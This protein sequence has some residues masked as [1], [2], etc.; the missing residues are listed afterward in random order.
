M[1]NSKNQSRTRVCLDARI[2]LSN[3][4]GWGR[5]ATELSLALAERDEFAITVLLPDSEAA[6]D[7]L[8]RG[9]SL[10]TMRIIQTRFIA[11]EP[12]AFWD[13]PGSEPAE[14]YA[15]DVEL[16]HSLTR[17]AHH[18]NVRLRV[19]TVHDIVPLSAT[20]FKLIYA[21]ATKR[22]LRVL[23]D[24][25]Y[26][27]ITDSAFTKGELLQEGTLVHSEINV[28]HLAAADC[29]HRLANDVAVDTQSAVKKFLYVGGAGA[30]KN[31]DRLG[32]AIKTVAK[33]R[34]DFELVLAGARDWGYASLPLME[35][36]HPIIKYVQYVS[37]HELVKY[38]REAAALIMPSLH[39]GFGL[40]L[41]EAIAS[42]TPVICSDI[43]PFKEIAGEYASY[44]NP[45]EVES[46]VSAIETFLDNPNSLRMPDAKMIDYYSWRRV[47]EET[48]QIYRSCLE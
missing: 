27:I 1:A 33:K 46:L 35:E 3:R 9:T 40:P 20:P 5:Y 7:F 29:F 45:L 30:N 38:Y 10:D 13:S 25:Q 19:A 32:E 37:D 26:K 22:A 6:H 43:A 14:D 28:V 8:R 34:M 36:K 18:T 17:F 4:R 23:R 12:D 48:A 39:E 11:G 31:L 42:R 21:A 24:E 41:V 2:A 44:F 15:G 16:V 47:A